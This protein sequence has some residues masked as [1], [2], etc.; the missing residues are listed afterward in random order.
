MFV[1][2]F[3]LAVVVIIA[4]SPATESAVLRQYNVFVNRGLREET[5]SL[6][7]DK[8]LV[9]KGNLIQVLPLPNNKD[10]A[11]KLEIDYDGTKNGYRA[12]Y[13]LTREEAVEVLRLSPSS[14]KSISG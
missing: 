8:D 10:Y 2:A 9:I 1:K 11:I 4:L 6:E 12:H 5:I 3:F 13:I 14:L 7:D